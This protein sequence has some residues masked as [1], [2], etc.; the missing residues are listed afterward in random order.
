MVR[1]GRLCCWSPRLCVGVPLVVY[2]VALP[3]GGAWCV[4]AAPVFGLGGTL[5][6]PALL[7][8]VRSLSYRSRSS[9]VFVFAVTA[10]LV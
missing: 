5:H 1:E 8:I 10:L 7:H 6:C 3:N 2:P 9:S 4:L